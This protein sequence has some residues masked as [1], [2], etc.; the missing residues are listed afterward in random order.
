VRESDWAIA[1]A[2][3]KIKVNAKDRY[4]MMVKRVGLPNFDRPILAVAERFLE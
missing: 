1:G 4:F 2:E 3:A